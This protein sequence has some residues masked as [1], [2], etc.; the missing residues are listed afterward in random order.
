VYSGRGESMTQYSI[1]GIK[2][3]KV[4]DIVPRINDVLEYIIKYIKEGKNKELSQK[5]QEYDNIYIVNSWG[6]IV[7][8]VK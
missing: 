1:I 7:Y 8:K 6:A 5:I 4:E 2:G 3:D